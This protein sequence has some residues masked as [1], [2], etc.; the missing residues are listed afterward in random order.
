LLASVSTGLVAA[1]LETSVEATDDLC[2][3]LAR[4]SLFLR[5]DSSDEWPDGSLHTRYAFT[6]GLVQ[7]VCAGRAAPARRQRWHLRIAERLEA[8]YGERADEVSVTLASHFQHAQVAPRAVH[9]FVVAA[10]RAQRRFASADAIRLYRVALELLPRLPEAP[11]DE[12][13][14]RILGGMTLPVLRLHEEYVRDPESTFVRRL[15]L[16]RRS[17]SPEKICAALLDFVFFRSIMGNHVAAWKLLDEVDG[18]IA[19]GGVP[20]ELVSQVESSHAVGAFWRGDFARALEILERVV[21]SEVEVMLA[22]GDRRVLHLNYLA[23]TTCIVGQ[24]DR[25]LREIERATSLAA[26]VGDPYTHGLAATMDGSIRMMRGDPPEA[27]R[28]SAQRV[29]DVPAWAP[30]H[31]PARMFLA[32]VKSREAPLDAAAADELIAQYRERIA[33]F[34]LGATTIATRVAAALIGSPREAVGL[35]I[36]DTILAD[37]L[38]RG[39]GAFRAELLAQRGDMLAGAEAV[40]AYRDAIQVARASGARLFELRAALG[41]HRLQSARAEIEAA[42]A[43]FVDGDQTADVIAARAILG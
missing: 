11:R 18:V 4:R 13:E 19:A 15:A 38:A 33:M 34:P 2:D 21:T 3:E 8:A 24:P 5:R 40:A 6:H 7:A 12:Y 42:L 17:G 28:A 41:L 22:V 37:S 25:G 23:M 36:L 9:Y 29:L 14:L 32:W 10:E 43:G 30:W 27:I 16:A 31:P 35:E 20:P 26:K 1:A 39:E